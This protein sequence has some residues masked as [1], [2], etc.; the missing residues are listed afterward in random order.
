MAMLT[1]SIACAVIVGATAAQLSAAV[2][3]DQTFTPA[4]WTANVTPAAGQSSSQVADGGNS[5]TIPDPFRRVTTQT[6]AFTQTFHINPS[7]V[8]DPD[9]T[10]IVSIDFTIDF[11][12]FAAFGEG[13]AYGL[14]IEQ[15]GMRYRAAYAI[16]DSDA[17]SFVWNQGGTNGLVAGD[18]IKDGG[19]GLPN[20]S[21][22]GEPISFGFWTGNTGGNGISIGYDNYGVTVH[23][24]PEPAAGLLMLIGGGFWMRRR[25]V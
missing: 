18:F 23:T 10:P 16:T 7:F 15:D 2:F 12:A 1:R 24:V 9:V 19:V 3:V 5:A 4:D 13:M 22:G 8:V 11:K 17:S 14:G 25:G 6:G 21:S 20:F